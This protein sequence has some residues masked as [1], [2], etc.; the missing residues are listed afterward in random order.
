MVAAKCDFSTA[1][2]GVQGQFPGHWKPS[3]T[4]RLARVVEMA[5]QAEHLERVDTIVLAIADPGS[6]LWT[7]A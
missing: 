5:V 6:R 7:V 4:L 1:R 2:H 3:R